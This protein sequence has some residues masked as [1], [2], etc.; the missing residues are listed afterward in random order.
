MIEKADIERVFARQLDRI[1]NPT[2][3]EGVVDVWKTACDK[4]GWKSMDEVAAIPFTM[5]T[6]TRGIGILEHTIVVTEGAI[7]LA[8]AQLHSYRKQ[9]YA[10]DMDRL[11]AGGL[12][13]DVGK[14]VEVEP[15]PDGGYRKSRN[16]LCTRHPISGA[17]LAAMAGLPDELVNTIACHAKEGEGRPQVPETVYIH[18]ADFAFFNPLVMMAGGKLILD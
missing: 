7:G 2:I 15:A 13:H 12:L 10:L 17:I 5:L 14:V 9:P 16:G 6:D 18:Q 8:E 3:R 1:Q 4:G 11:V